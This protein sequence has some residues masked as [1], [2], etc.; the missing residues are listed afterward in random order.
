MNYI[1]ELLSFQCLTWTEH[2]LLSARELFFTPTLRNPGNDTYTNYIP[3]SRGTPKFLNSRWTPWTPPIRASS[4]ASGRT[5]TAPGPRVGPASCHWLSYRRLPPSRCSAAFQ[6]VL[7]SAKQLA[8]WIR[9]LDRQPPGRDPSAAAIPTWLRWGVDE[10]GTCSTHWQSFGR[11]ERRGCRW[12]WFRR[13]DETWHL[14]KKRLLDRTR[15]FLLT[16][17]LLVGK[18]EKLQSCWVLEICSALYLSARLCEYIHIYSYER[19]KKSQTKLVENELSSR[20]VVW[21]DTIETSGSRR[22]SIF[23]T[24]SLEKGQK[25]LNYLRN[26]FVYMY[27]RNTPHY[28]ERRE[29]QCNE[30]QPRSRTE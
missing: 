9:T 28:K 24:N 27:T 23:R 29:P 12:K 1:V 22:E 14:T 2:S 3:F 16:N 18:R 10:D 13:N 6:F 4:P 20:G 11:L 15:P 7:F 21:I 25:K 26:N 17:I 19:S 8:G 5:G 30:T